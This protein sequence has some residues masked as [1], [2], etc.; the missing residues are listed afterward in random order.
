I[1]KYLTTCEGICAEDRYKVLRFI[2]NLTMGVAS[3]SY[4]TESMHGAGSP[5]AQRIM[6]SRQANLEEKKKLVKKI[7]EIE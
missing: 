4:R 3:V 5:Q 2:E 1:E 6:I 7:L